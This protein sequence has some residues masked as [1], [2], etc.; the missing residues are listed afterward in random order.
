M[1]PRNRPHLIEGLGGLARL[2]GALTRDLPFDRMFAVISLSA[3]K[4]LLR[5]APMAAVGG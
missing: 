4:V 5:I 3:G 1:S 2:V